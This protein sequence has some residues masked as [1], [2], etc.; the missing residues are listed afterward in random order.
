M[1]AQALAALALIAGCRNSSAPTSVFGSPS[2]SPASP[3]ATVA[4][5]SPDASIIASKLSLTE[6]CGAAQQS[7]NGNVL[8]YTCPSGK[9]SRSAYLL[10]QP[11]APRVF[12]LS[13]SATVE[14]VRTATCEDIR[15]G[16]TQPSELSALYAAAIMMGWSFR[17]QVLT[18]Q[19]LLDC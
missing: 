12:A 18:G 8:R 7:M 15:A 4:T 2:E 19:G 1:T 9:T 3:E 10:L 11:Q 13:S 6:D 5:A 14:Q 16:G 17:D